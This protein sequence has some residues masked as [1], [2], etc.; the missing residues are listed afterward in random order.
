LGEVSL[1]SNPISFIAPGQSYRQL[2]NNGF[3]ILAE[4]K[5]TKFDYTISYSSASHQKFTERIETDLSYL[6]QAT[7]PGKSIDDHLS[8]I[9]KELASLAKDFKN[10]IQ[11][12]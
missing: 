1:F 7:V 6:K 11:N 4:G 5:P 12:H 3:T 2:V 9:E 10:S 8:S